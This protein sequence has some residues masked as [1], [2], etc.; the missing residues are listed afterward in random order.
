VSQ[1]HFV[2]HK[3]HMDWPEIEPAPTQ[4]KAGDYP[5]E[6]WHGLQWHSI[7]RRGTRLEVNQCEQ[8]TK[9]EPL[10]PHNRHH[11]SC[12]RA[13]SIAPEWDCDPEQGSN[14]GWQDM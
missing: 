11:L 13:K 5:P 10:W 14:Y 8:C 3:S 12:G 7:A 4:C 2:H 1:C 9:H 6:P